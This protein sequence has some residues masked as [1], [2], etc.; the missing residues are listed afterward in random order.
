MPKVRVPYVC[1]FHVSCVRVA[2]M[3]VR[4]VCGACAVCA[5]TIESRML[6]GFVKRKDLIRW[7]VIS[8]AE[9][10]DG[11]S[12][13]FE[14]GGGAGTGGGGLSSAVAGML[15]PL[16]RRKRRRTRNKRRVGQKKGQEGQIGRASCR[17]RVL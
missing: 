1:V 3:C 9:P 16:T 13:D 14:V 12:T 17:E 7:L 5:V 15:G 6:L 2:Y 11:Q 10:D 8:T 4:C